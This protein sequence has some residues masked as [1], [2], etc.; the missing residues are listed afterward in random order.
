INAHGT[1]TLYNDLVE[2]RAIKKVFKE[3]AKK[4]PVSSTKSQVGHTLGASGGVELITCI[5]AMNHNFFPPTLNYHTP[6]PQCDLDYVPNSSREGIINYALSNNFGFGG[7]N[8]S[9]VIKRY[10]GE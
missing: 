6:D 2:T 3:Y 10:K 8:C 9:I 1:G 4:I 7:N 5:L